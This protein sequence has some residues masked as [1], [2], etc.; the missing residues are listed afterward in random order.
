[1]KKASAAPLLFPESLISKVEVED[2]ASPISDKIT[3]IKSA[4]TR[5]TPDSFLKM[6]FDFF[7]ITSFSSFD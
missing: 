5:A 1:V 4:T 3:I 6:R 7:L 2:E